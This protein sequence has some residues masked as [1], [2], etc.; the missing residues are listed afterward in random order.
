VG[1][2]SRCVG[3]SLPHTPV[4]LPLPPFPFPSSPLLALS[5]PACAFATFHSEPTWTHDCCKSFQRELSWPAAIC[6]LSASTA[7]QEVTR[8]ALPTHPGGLPLPRPCPPP[9]LWS[10]CAGTQFNAPRAVGRPPS[11]N[12]MAIAKG[13]LKVGSCGTIPY[14][15]TSAN[16]LSTEFRF[17]QSENM[18]TERYCKLF[19]GPASPAGI[20]TESQTAVQ[21]QAGTASDSDSESQA[22][23]AGPPGSLAETLHTGGTAS[24]SESACP[25]L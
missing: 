5:C 15:A 16:V 17:T 21:A 11:A 1:D 20:T 22:G 18:V 10:G 13:L 6:A 8:H 19:A 3:G 7:Q 24:A 2:K 12:R 25:G 14:F 4:T 23:W 9:P